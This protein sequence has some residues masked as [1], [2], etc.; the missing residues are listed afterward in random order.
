MERLGDQ[1]AQLQAQLADNAIY[2]NSQ[3]DRL[4]SLLVEKARVD[5]LL[6]DTEQAWLT[7]G[8][9]LEIA[10]QDG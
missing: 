8:E 3:K 10:E 6:D 2:E 1:Q 9:D 4:K 7:A 5:A